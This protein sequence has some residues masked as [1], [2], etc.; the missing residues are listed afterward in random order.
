[1]T[2]VLARPLRQLRSSHPVAMAIVGV[3]H[4]VHEV[5]SPTGICL[6]THNLQL[7]MTLEDTAENKGA[8]NVLVAT[9]NRHEGVDLWTAS[10]FRYALTRSQDMKAQR[11]LQLDRCFPELVVDRAIVVL[12]YGKTGHHHAPQTH[13]LDPLEILDAFVGRAHRGLP[14]PQKP[15]RTRAA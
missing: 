15:R 4:S 9:D 10:R 12:Y 3:V 13:G 1:L 14:Q 2:K 11:H 7:G 6:N 5:R 8:Y